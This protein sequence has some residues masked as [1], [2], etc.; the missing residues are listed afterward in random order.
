MSSEFEGVA[1][2]VIGNKSTL[3]LA[4]VQLVVTG[5]PDAGAKLRIEGGVA[6]VGTSKTC[7]LLLRD[8]TVSR[9]HCE[10]R[11]TED[12]VRLIDSGSTNGSVVDGV[13]VRDAFLAN[14]STLQIGGTTLRIELKDDA[15]TI[16]ISAR[17]A[18][19][20]ILG[21]SV[22]MRRMYSV[23]ERAA[24]T[25]TTVL[26]HGE[27]G[28]GKEL[29][30]RA[31]HDASPRS[32]GPFVAFDC[33]A[34]APN[35]V[36]SELFGHMRGA[37]TGAVADR[38][39]VFEEAHGGT[40]FL[41]ELGELPLSLQPKLL[42]AL[43][44]RQ[45]KRLGAAQPRS[46]DVRVVAATNRP[47]AR[48]VNAGTFRED[49]YYRL[50]VVEIELP[51]LRARRGDIPLLAKHFHERFAGKGVPMS[52]ELASA[53]AARNWPGN[54]RELRNFIECSVHVGWSPSDAAKE[55]RPLEDL[56]N[57]DVPFREARRAWMRA[58]VGALLDHAGGNVTRAAESAGLSRRFLQRLLARLE[59]DTD[60]DED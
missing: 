59:R 48:M 53:V 32:Q 41:D 37:F 33:G 49:L 39:G 2:D 30:A 55:T 25:E 24:P 40:L 3:K 56:V 27:T 21:A 13:R 15:V 50:A 51:P 16:P 1:T 58:Y 17:D 44:S 45:V 29:V 31:L 19:G 9:S 10:I 46:V 52:P 23:I 8:P 26:V 11:A 5:G 47:L 43:E 6:R 12:G 4:E 54:V 7:Q 36:E 60:D 42:R 18:F 38:K 20:P 34:L 35:L 14:G 57:I 22:E 28:T